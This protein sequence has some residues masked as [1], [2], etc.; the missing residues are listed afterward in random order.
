MTDNTPPATTA[1]TGKTWE[2]LEKESLRANGNPFF[3][4]GEVPDGSAVTMKVA[5]FEMDPAKFQ[6]KFSK[7]EME[8]I[9]NGNPFRLCVSG[10]RLAGAI[11]KIRPVVGDLITLT[12]VGPA[13]RER[14]W[15]AERSVVAAVARNGRIDG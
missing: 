15:N 4:I 5:G 6:G 2:D 7:F 14:K 10:S 13:G 12:A 9:Q 1:T 8:I 11:A 3:P